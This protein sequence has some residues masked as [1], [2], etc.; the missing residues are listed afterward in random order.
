MFSDIRKD[1]TGL[2]A[3]GTSQSLLRLSVTLATV[4]FTAPCMVNAQTTTAP[5]AK[6]A[7][8]ATNQS[9]RERDRILLK[10]NPIASEYQGNTSPGSFFGALS[11]A[12][13]VDFRGQFRLPLG[14]EGAADASIEANLSY[15]DVA[16]VYRPGG[17][18]KL[19]KSFD[20][21]RLQL[22]A[23]K[24]T[25]ERKVDFY[26]ARWV[27]FNAPEVSDQP[28]LL[29][30]FP[31]YSQDHFD[32]TS[33]N[34]QWRADYII[35]GNSY[36]SYEGL[37]TNYDDIATRNRL[38]YQIGAGTLNSATLDDD[39]STLRD[40][41]MVDSR[42]RRYFHRMETAR[43]INRH[44]LE[45]NFEDA[46][47]ALELGLYYSRWVNERLWLPWNFVDQ[48]I[49]AQ[50]DIANPY[51]PQTTV[52]NADVFD[53]SQS[54]FANYRPTLTTTTDTDYAFVTDWSQKLTFSAHPVWLGSGIIWRNKERNNEN[55]RSVYTSTEDRFNLTEVV[56]GNQN[57]TIM[58]G[59]TTIPA[60]MDL[61]LGEPYL[62]SNASQFYFN[63]AQSF[64]ESIQD[65]YTSEETVSSAYI[66]AYQQRESWFWRV[67]LRFEHTETATRGAV[68]GPVEAGITELG[69]AITAVNIAGQTIEEDFSH[70]DAAFVE[71][72]NSYHHFMP[73]VE[74][75]YQLTPSTRLKFTY[76]EQLMRPQ[77]FDTVRY[78]RI[79]PPTRTI[80]EGS[81]DL[82]PTTIQNFYAGV[83]YQRDSV[84]KL[85]AGVYYNDIE[86][87]FYD[88]RVTEELEGILYD[89][90]R[91]E[92]GKD[93]YIQGLQSYWAQRF[94]NTG[95][96]LI[97]IKASYTYSDTEA[98]LLD[99]TIAMPERARHRVMVNLLLKNNQW[100]YTTAF[101]WQSEALDDVGPDVRQDTIREKVLM[102]NQSFSWRFNPHLSAKFSLNNVLDYPDR[103]H[104]REQKRVVNN[105]YSGTTAK[106]GISYSF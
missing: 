58:D 21:L 40:V 12:E 86:N 104:L 83:E 68:S 61:L 30:G 77:Y 90:T 3:V 81:P 96:D 79:N 29:L 105:L 65:I 70:F 85:Y 78:R 92:N 26:E 44:R 37:L 41:S 4:M 7:D 42:I 35:S 46:D 14:K 53:I 56:G 50:Y 98:N 62:A 69:D 64:L 84:G 5:T 17:S 97:D 19:A 89:V 36:I 15:Q 20:A 2:K 75:R 103:A 31:R 60:G 91:V 8:D 33:F 32:T 93:G 18:I 11:D 66:D 94:S 59:R 1:Q 45:F 80:T 106:L 88:S 39:G 16:E 57:V 22:R 43:D 27:A 72:G 10:R 34:M 73:A 54:W 9:A 13:G 74:L 71:G 25:L 48:G 99:R 6:A 38:E 82:E 49:D 24:N 67:G 28:A 100:Q 55:Y 47:T 95:L 63:P 23:Q 52:N 87:F 51:L 76:F 102:W 101:A